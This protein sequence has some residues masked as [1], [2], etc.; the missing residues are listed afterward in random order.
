MLGFMAGD[1]EV[2]YFAAGTKISHVGLTLI[3]SL[4]TVMLPHC[5]FLLKKG[6]VT[7]F[8]SMIGK[9]LNITLASSLPM[10]IG[11][12]ILASP[13]TMIFCGSEYVA[14]IPVLLL[15]APVII[16][17]SLTNLM[18]I[19]ILYPKDKINLVIWSVSGGS[20]INLI[21]NFIFIPLYG[22]VGA[23]IATLIAEFT[24]LLIQM[25]GGNKYY[26]FKLHNLFNKR[27]II[28]SLVMG[29]TIYIAIY[30]IQ[31][32]IIQLI[33][34]IC[35]GISIYTIFLMILKDPLITEIKNTITR[36]I[37]YAKH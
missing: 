36:K 6:D 28:G 16:F 2:G 19:Q 14:A 29:L 34:G 12:M 15:N 17:I 35:V 27:Y 9:S 25:I 20:I 24:V 22:A 31:S 13:V 23:A 32:Y 5:S 11:L 33:I 3:F 26:P 37:R 7:G 4:G 30:N 18:G 8:N 1:V 10:T 21:L